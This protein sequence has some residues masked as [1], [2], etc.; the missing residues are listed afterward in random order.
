MKKLIMLAWLTMTATVQ[1]GSCWKSFVNIQKASG[2][3]TPDVHLAK[4]M[5]VY[6]NDPDMLERAIAI[7]FLE[8]SWRNVVSDS[9]KDFGLFQFSQDTIENMGLDRNY[10]M[11]NLFYQFHSFNRLMK[12]KLELCRH[13]EVPE[14]CWLSTTPEFHEPYAAKYKKIQAVIQHHMRRNR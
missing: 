14:A 2:R 13:R 10:L 7:S 11:S 3:K 1:A 6:F 9:G 4:Y 8:S 5:C 12:Q